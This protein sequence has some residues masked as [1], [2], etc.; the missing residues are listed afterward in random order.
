MGS[1]IKIFPK[2]HHCS[3]SNE[4]ASQPFVH[5]IP[6][7]NLALSVAI[8]FTGLSPT[9]AIKMLNSA[10]VACHTVGTYHKHARLYLHP[11]VWTFWLA[12]KMDLVEELCR[13]GENLVLDGDGRADSP[14][15]SAKYGSYTLM[16]LQSKKVMDIELVQSNE[17]GGSNNMELE[18]LV[19]SLDYLERENLE[20]FSQFIS[21]RHLKV[22][23]YMSTYVPN[24]GMTPGMWQRAKA[25]KLRKLPN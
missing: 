2:C 25:K 4:W 12:H 10:N 22:R 6:A 18:G 19:R 14:G 11:A 9:K 16:E 24:I 23:K 17:V 5:N 1:F 3:L 21:D 7:G 20:F 8:L 13:S 15:H